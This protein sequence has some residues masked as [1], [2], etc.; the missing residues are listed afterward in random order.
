MVAKSGDLM[1]FILDET[2]N[3][4]KDVVKNLEQSIIIGNDKRKIS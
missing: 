4:L 3:S 2:P 1:V